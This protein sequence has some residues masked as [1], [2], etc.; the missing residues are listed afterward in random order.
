MACQ[1]IVGVTIPLS[2][3]FLWP[4]VSGG[5]SLVGQIISPKGKNSQS[6][7]KIHFDVHGVEY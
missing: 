3:F 7:D 2:E 6:F 5:H 1:N 4:L